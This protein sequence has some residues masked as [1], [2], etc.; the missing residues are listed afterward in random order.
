MI[1][2]LMYSSK[3]PKIAP[4]LKKCFESVDDLIFDGGDTMISAIVSP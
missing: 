2:V 3:P 1:D 4:Y